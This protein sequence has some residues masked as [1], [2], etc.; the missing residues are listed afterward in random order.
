MKKVIVIISIFLVLFIIFGGVD[1]NETPTGPIDESPS[2]FDK[3]VLNG[4]MGDSL[5]Y[6]YNGFEGDT[7]HYDLTLDPDFPNFVSGRWYEE[8]FS[9]GDIEIVK[10]NTGSDVC[11]ITATK[12][13]D[14]GTYCAVCRGYITRDG[15]TWDP[16]LPQIAWD[17]YFYFPSETWNKGDFVNMF[18]NAEIFDPVIKESYAGGLFIHHRKNRENAYLFVWDKSDSTF[19]MIA[20]DIPIYPDTWYYAQ[21]I[22]DTNTKRYIS[23][24]IK[25]PELSRVWEDIPYEL[26]TYGRTSQVNVHG[27]VF[28]LNINS[29]AEGVYIYFD[30]NLARFPKKD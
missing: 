18:I 2:G 16:N 15:I 11:K 1:Q 23:C 22:I 4:K 3:V 14:D 17:A 10:T 6:F 20:D 28:Y 30:N 5:W 21:L 29:N 25:G 26:V 12:D 7:I 9:S 13:T 27:I 19:K 24:K 8:Q